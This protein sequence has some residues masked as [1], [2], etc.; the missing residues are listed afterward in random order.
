MA[1]VDGHVIFPIGAY[2]PQAH[3]QAV[4][5]TGVRIFRFD[6]TISHCFDSK[7]DLT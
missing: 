4:E 7:I 2:Y 3:P 5:N 1:S 6:R